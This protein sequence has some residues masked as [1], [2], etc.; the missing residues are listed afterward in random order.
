MI[1]TDAATLP[2]VG[3]KALLR[4]LAQRR[5]KPLYGI[6]SRKHRKVVSTPA[7]AQVRAPCGYGA[8]CKKNHNDRTGMPYPQLSENPRASLWRFAVLVDPHC[9]DMQ[10]A[11]SGEVRKCPWVHGL[12]G[13]LYHRHRKPLLVALGRQPRCRPYA[14]P[15]PRFYVAP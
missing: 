3:Q 9:I 8:L 4:S 11:Y 14:M 6:D 5:W 7:Q 1:E 15:S 13:D 12:R 10:N 2:M